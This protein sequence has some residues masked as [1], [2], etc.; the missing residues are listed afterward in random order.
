MQ[1][2]LC[3]ILA[4]PLQPPLNL[5]EFGAPGDIGHG[6]GD[7]RHQGRLR[8][9]LYWSTL[10]ID[11]YIYIY[12]RRVSR[13]RG[14]GPKIWKPF[15]FFFF[16]FQFFRGGGGPA[17]KIAEK[18]IFSTKKGAKYRWNS[19]IFALMTFFFFFFLLFNF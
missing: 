11:M 3:R 2:P 13:K 8:T 5:A 12:I 14:G 7:F 18:L 16:T 10:F 1:P 9:P 15:F 6:L 17:P 4:G 19:L